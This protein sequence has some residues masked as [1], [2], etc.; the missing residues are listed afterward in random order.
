MDDEIR[1]IDTKFFVLFH[2][3]VDLMLLSWYG[4]NAKRVLQRH[5]H[6]TMSLEYY[7]KYIGRDGNKDDNV[8][9][10]A[11][12]SKQYKTN[13]T[14][15]LESLCACVNYTTKMIKMWFWMSKMNKI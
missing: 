9:A 13:I 1:H 2:S 11:L 12:W 8:M 10:L 15:Y 3:N 14:K 6:I 4:Q 5:G 7:N